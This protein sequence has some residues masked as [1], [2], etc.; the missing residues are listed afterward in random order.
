MVA[1]FT[2]AI[3]R[4]N[5]SKGI[6]QGTAF[7]VTPDLAVTCAHAIEATGAGPGETVDLI[8]HATKEPAQAHI[9]SDWWRAPDAEDVAI[10]RF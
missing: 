8:F 10:L 2:R 5:D 6:T 1:N 3:L 7:L 4:V 9:I